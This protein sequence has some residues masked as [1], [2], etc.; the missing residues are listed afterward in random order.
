M[1]RNI[2]KKCCEK[3]K[4]KG[5]HC[6]D[7]PLTHKK[8]KNYK[9][10][11]NQT[12]SEVKKERKLS[13]QK[14]SKV[15]CIG[16]LT[17]GGDCQGLNAAIRAVAKSVIN[18]Y[19]LEVIGILD[20]FRGLVENRTKHLGDNELSGILTLGG[21]ILGT[22]RD[23][24]DKMT[25]GGKTL[26]MTSQAIE[27][28]HKM[29]LDYLVCLGGGGTQKNALKLIKKSKDVNIITLPKTIDNDIAE[30]DVSFGYDTAVQIAVEA[31][32]R[33][34]STA[35]SHH[36]VMVVEIM[37]H[38]TGWL[39][40][41]AG[42][43]GGADIVLIP[44]IH[45]S[46]DTVAR[47]VIERNRRGKRFSIVAVAEGAIPKE[48]TAKVLKDK[49]KKTK[50][51]KKIKDEDPCIS[52]SVGSQLAR[53]IQAVTRLE[54]RL[55]SLG[56]TQRGGTPSAFDRILATKLGTKAAQLIS[57]GTSGV[58][59]AVKGENLVPVPLE[60]IAGKRKYI[61]LDHPI[62]ESLRELKICLGEE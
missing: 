8:S 60:K 49:K 61:P 29:H 2:K 11:S 25:I 15:Q 42:L 46:L 13:M 59:V 57:E 10:L 4:K 26:D 51:K 14:K 55:T 7:C 27:N 54:T 58:M 36:R 41:S 30:T 12:T 18:S 48:E 1:G 23:K 16:I 44:E 39:T 31:I 37:G 6:S 17:S 33:L 34:H 5:K 52:E 24:P 20:G 38:N 45:Y 22:S 35:S 47:Y 9:Q 53:Q 21:T 50:T 56:H 43:A 40:A 62:L 19:N 3:Y 28:F 32:D